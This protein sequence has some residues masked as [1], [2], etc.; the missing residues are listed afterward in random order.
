MQINEEIYHDRN[1]LDLVTPVQDTLPLIK[2]C[3]VKNATYKIR[4]GTAIGTYEITAETLKSSDNVRVRMVSDL[5]N[6]VMREGRV[7]DD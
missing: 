4:N 6:T 3:K 7:S 5:L 2:T 1:S